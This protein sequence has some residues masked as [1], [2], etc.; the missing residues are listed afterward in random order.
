MREEN[1]L[2]TKASKQDDRKER[3]QRH[4]RVKT[5]Y[6]RKQREGLKEEI[7]R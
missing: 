5:K 4:A 3:R 6:K 7:E 1:R 2:E